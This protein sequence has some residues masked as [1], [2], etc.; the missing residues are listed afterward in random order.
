MKKVNFRVI[1]SENDLKT[2]NKSKRSQ[3]NI[4]HTYYLNKFSAMVIMLIIFNT[5]FF[6]TLIVI[7]KFTVQ[8]SFLAHM[9]YHLNNS[10][11]CRSL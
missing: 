10:F 9:I 11:S 5:H 6:F 7:S 3:S 2:V 8:L 1:V 4:I